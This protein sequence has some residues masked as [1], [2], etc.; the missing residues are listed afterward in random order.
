MRCSACDT[1][2]DD[3]T[4]NC[5]CN[6]PPVLPV[7]LKNALTDANAFCGRACQLN[8]VALWLDYQG[9]KDIGREVRDIAEKVYNVGIA[10][11][12]AARRQG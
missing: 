1:E 2:I 3:V 8:D 5:R 10:R 11:I 9:E 6:T 4:G 7:P 12:T